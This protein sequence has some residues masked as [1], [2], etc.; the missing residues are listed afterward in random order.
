MRAEGILFEYLRTSRMPAAKCTFVGKQ[1]PT[2]LGVIFV[3]SLIA[4]QPWQ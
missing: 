4:G 3:P 1:L 2:A